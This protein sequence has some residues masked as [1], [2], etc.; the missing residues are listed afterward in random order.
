MRIETTAMPVRASFGSMRLAARCRQS[1]CHQ[2]YGNHHFTDGDTA[3]MMTFLASR[4]SCFHRRWNNSKFSHPAGRPSGPSVI[5]AHGN[6][7]AAVF[8]ALSSASD[9]GLQHPPQL[10]GDLLIKSGYAAAIVADLGWIGGRCAAL[11]L[12]QLVGGDFCC[13]HG[14]GLLRI[15]QRLQRT[16]GCVPC[17]CSRSP[18]VARCFNA[19][20]G[21]AKHPLL[22][23]IGGQSSGLT[24]CCLHASALDFRC[25]LQQLLFAAMPLSGDV[26]QRGFPASAASSSRFCRR[27]LGWTGIV[28]LAMQPLLRSSW[29]RW[30]ASVILCCFCSMSLRSCCNCASS[31]PL[32][33]C[34]ATPGYQ[35]SS[36]L[37]CFLQACA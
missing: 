9:Q 26:C 18:S 3:L 6:G 5:G 20:D 11:Q 28:Q 14:N 32:R 4:H 16:A 31:R 19:T 12:A 34:S 37:H 25:L 8:Y 27:S 29:S 1:Q 35:L 33:T 17:S 23:R 24:Q 2:Q 15:A 22:R 10:G 30:L 7:F 21:Y 36:C 13:G